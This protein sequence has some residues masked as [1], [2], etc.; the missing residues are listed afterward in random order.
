MDNPSLVDYGGGKFTINGRGYSVAFGKTDDGKTEC[1]FTGYPC[2]SSMLIDVDVF[3]S[4][5]GF[6]E[7]YFAC[8]D[9]TDL[10]WRAWLLGYQ[11]LFCPT[12]VVYHVGGGT[13]GRGR[14]SPLKALYGTRGPIITVLKNLE[15]RTLLVGLL[16]TLVYDVNEAFLLLKKGDWQCLRMKFKAFP[17]LFK[18]LR[19]ILGKR[20]TIQKARVVSDQWLCDRGF[21]TSFGEAFIEHSRLNKLSSMAD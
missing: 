9:D 19:S 12:S 15:F 13:A 11:T 16:L 1:S 10:G 2:A 14:L 21:L 18:N 5:G 4:L 6:D 17:W 8:L 3:K 20:S 7:D